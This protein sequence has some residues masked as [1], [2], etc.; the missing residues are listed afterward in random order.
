MMHL[1]ESRAKGS[2]VR[3]GALLFRCV[4]LG[5]LACAP[6]PAPRDPVGGPALRVLVA[7][8]GTPVLPAPPPDVAREISRALA[9]ATGRRLL[10]VPCAS[11]EDALAKL[12]G[13]EADVI[14][15]GLSSAGPPADGV[16]FSV[17]YRH[18]ETPLVLGFRA[19]DV[20]LRSRANELLISQAFAEREEIHREDLEGIRRRG[21]LRLIATPHVGS[22]YL[23]RGDP[24]G[25]EHDLLQR[26]AKEEGLTLEVVSPVDAAELEAWLA[27]GRGDVV[28]AHPDGPRVA[29][30]RMAVTR[31]LAVVDLVVVARD[32]DP[33]PVRDLADLAGRV[34][35]VRAGGP[36]RDVANELADAVEGL[37]IE[38][39]PDRVGAVDLLAGVG[40]GRYDVALAPASLV[41]VE[42]HAGRRLE[43]AIPVGECRPAWGVRRSNPAL[44]AAL[45]AFL[46][47]E[48]RGSEYNVLWRKYMRSGAAVARA[49]SG[50]DRLSPWDPVVRR[51]AAAYDLDW[52]L[53]VAQMY[54]ESRFD[55]VCVSPAGAVGLMQIVPET[56]A[57]LG[58]EDPTDPEDSIR[59]GAEYL[60]RLAGLYSPDLPLATRLRFALA[61]YDAGHGHVMDARRLAAQMGLSPDRWYGHVERAMLLLEQPEHFERARC[62]YCRGS[63]TVRYVAEIDRRYRLYVRNVPQDPVDSSP[64]AHAAS[65][66]PPA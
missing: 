49:G 1:R 41:R 8:E 37:T 6:G 55:P 3:T 56:A 30:G 27:E 7:P 20:Q 66:L 31:A 25:F 44:L 15:T 5:S 11:G 34:L 24:R 13:G 17:P 45:D 32:D 42:Q 18:V 36:E 23:D 65:P 47:R 16:A 57:R 35:A 4:V 60:H 2:L 22:Y 39:V 62:G 12:L 29:G 38:A 19:E 58:L 9:D 59:A 46:A 40:D 53:L 54:Q 50:A 63:E 64:A 43:A 33:H 21:S 51:W 14:A 26:F 10:L 52:R 48:F 28:A 61:S